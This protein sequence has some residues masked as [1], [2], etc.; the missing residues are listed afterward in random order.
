M[1]WAGLTFIVA[2]FLTPGV[3]LFA[4]ETDSLQVAVGESEYPPF[5]NLLPNGGMEKDDDLN[6]VP[7]GWNIYSWIPSESGPLRD[8]VIRYL[9][10]DVPEIGVSMEGRKTFLGERAV[11]LFTTTGKIGP[12]IWTTVDLSPGVYTLNLVARSMT[13]GSRVVATFLAQEGRLTQIDEKWRWIAHSEFLPYATPAAAIIVNDWTFEEGGILVDHISL[14][15]V[16][17]EIRYEKMVDLASGENPYMIEI[18]NPRGTVLP[19]GANLEVLEPSGTLIRKNMELEVGEGESRFAFTIRA[20]SAGEYTAS[21]ELYNPR[22]TSILYK[23]EGIRAS[24]SGGPEELAGP[25]SHGSYPEDF[26]PLGISVK[27]Y[28]LDALEGKGMNTIL[29]KDPDPLDIREILGKAHRMGLKCIIEIDASDSSYLTENEI[30]IVEQARGSSSLL[31]YSLLS[32]WGYGKKKQEFLRIAAGEVRKLDPSSPLFL[33]NYLPGPLDARVL[34]SVDA[35]C[36]D[37]FPITVPMKPLY[38]IANWIEKPREMG[39]AGIKELAVVQAFAGWPYARKLPTV[40]EIRTLIRLSLA[41]GA[42]GIIFHTF[43]GDFP[44]FNDPVSSNWDVRRAPELWNGI[45][46]LV[47]ETADF[48]RKFGK[49]EKRDLPIDFL[50]EG[51]LDV[52][53]FS[54]GTSLYIQVVNILPAAVSIRSISPLFHEGDAIRTFPDGSQ[55]ACG[56]GF[57]EDMLPTYAVRVYSLGDLIP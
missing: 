4:V 23:D 54:D 43:S 16:P 15:K 39:R 37:P 27:G 3:L 24:L 36:V 52:A 50:P 45:G 7:D 12:G 28:E 48:H 31:G 53:T 21:I 1:T 19:V 14:I 17:F 47:R 56:D 8:A 55:I 29:L 41:H 46:E 40:D 13:G 35:L 20:D 44:F 38:T 2:A 22:T 6:N 32:G 26:F 51:A 42:D 10:L 18:A 5:E 34:G 30:A 25:E 57:F 49:P 11:R 9:D 33:R